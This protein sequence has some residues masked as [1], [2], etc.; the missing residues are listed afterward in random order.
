[1][2]TW[3]EDDAFWR[4]AASVLFSG[5][6]LAAAAEEV[7]RVVALG[8]IQPGARILDLCCGVGRHA[9]ELARR[10]CRVT[11]V[12]RTAEYLALAREQAAAE[13]LDVE[14][15]QADMR[16]FVRP[17]AFDAAINLFTSFGYFEDPADDR[18]AAENLCRSL[19][20]GGALVMDL[21][22]KEVLARI[23][24]SRDWHEEDGALVL[25]ER[26]VAQ[27]WGWIEN[28][29]ILIRGD[30]RTE[31][32]LGH[33]LYAATELVALLRDVG[34]AQAKA[35]GGLDGSPYDHAAKRLVVVA[36]R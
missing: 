33:R 26:R 31:L 2:K 36:R 32:Q 15:V 21:L 7:D 22:G 30:R 14:W 18:R 17:Q 5:R 28:R 29:W 3:H 19:V 6:R 27:E 13:G 10:G 24:R 4:E 1:M 9:L 35:Y 20:P 23:F 11:G 34:F 8:E 12:D 25:E 16:E